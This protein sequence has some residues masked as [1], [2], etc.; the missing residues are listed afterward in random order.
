VLRQAV[1][2]NPA[3]WGL[4]KKCS[5]KKSKPE[6]WT[7]RVFLRLRERPIRGRIVSSESE[8]C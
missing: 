2:M 5:G 7:A 6:F 1:E 4:R 3:S 8:F